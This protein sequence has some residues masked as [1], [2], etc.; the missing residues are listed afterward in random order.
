MNPFEVF[1]HASGT[2]AG[3]TPNVLFIKASPSHYVRTIGLNILSAS[4]CLGEEEDEGRLQGLD[5]NTLTKE[6]RSSSSDYLLILYG[7]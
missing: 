4:A 3:I 1:K 7:S 6:Q 5:G 2:F